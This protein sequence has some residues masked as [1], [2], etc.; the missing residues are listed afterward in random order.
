MPLLEQAAATDGELRADALYNL[1]NARLTADDLP[2]AIA[3][4]EA[5]LRHDPGHRAAKH[6][7][8]LALRQ[9]EQ[10]QQQQQ[11]EP[12]EGGGEGGGEPQPGDEGGEDPQQGEPEEQPEGEEQ[13]QG[14]PGGAPQQ[15]P[16][17][18]GQRQGGR[19]PRLPQFDPQEDMSADQAANLLEAV[20]NLERE[21]RRAQADAERQA[22]A[23]TTVE[24]DW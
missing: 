3:S 19:S 5:S 22:R 13:E 18:G 6:N 14:Q 15:P 4:Y 23:R 21:Q 9:L 11:Q 12:S 16:S 24:K 10:E 8:E 17:P 2:G 20:E 1:G 7:L